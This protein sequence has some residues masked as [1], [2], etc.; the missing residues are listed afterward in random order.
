MGAS[1]RLQAGWERTRGPAGSPWGCCFGWRTIRSD[2]R[3]RFAPPSRS[4]GSGGRTR[5]R[6]S[7]AWESGSPTSR[8]RSFRPAW[9]ANVSPSRS[10]M[11]A[12]I[13][14]QYLMRAKADFDHRA[15][16]ARYR[17]EHAHFGL[18]TPGKRGYAQLHVD[19]K[20]AARRLERGT[21]RVELRQRLRTPS[22]IGRGLPRRSRGL[23]HPA[24]PPWPTK[25]ASSTAKT[26]SPSP[27]IAG[28]G[29]SFL[30]TR[31][32]VARFLVGRGVTKKLKPGPALPALSG[33]RGVR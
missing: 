12:P 31:L 27:A 13:R 1:V 20:F 18:A 28:P 24:R 10:R 4:S 6:P 29:F 17:D 2:A 8:F 21:R 16:L 32:T 23:P 15:Y 25:P 9:W 11:R 33:G 3:R 30:V 26:P 22:R 19:L 5:K 7:P 14:Y